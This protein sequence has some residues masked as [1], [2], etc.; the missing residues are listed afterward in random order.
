MSAHLVADAIKMA[1]DVLDGK[2]PVT[3]GAYNNGKK[4]VPAKQTAVVVVSKDNVK[5]ALID[6]GYY[7]ATDFTFPN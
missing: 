3:T 2:T 4:D 1:V 5:A 6:S 7:Q